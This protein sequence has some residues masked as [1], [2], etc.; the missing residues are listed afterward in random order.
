MFVWGGLKMILARGEA[1]AVQEAKQTMTWA[2]YGLVIIFFSY[3]IVNA[4]T[5]ALDKAGQAP[6]AGQTAR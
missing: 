3:A 5:G 6:P 2:T 1:K 4:V